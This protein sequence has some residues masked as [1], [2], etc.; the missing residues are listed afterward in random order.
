MTDKPEIAGM[1]EARS[2]PEPVKARVQLSN[3][4]VSLLSEQLYQSPMKAVEELVVN[5]YDAGAHNCRLF[6]PDPAAQASGK[7]PFIIVFDDGEGMN[8]EGLEAL[9]RVGHSDKQT[10]GVVG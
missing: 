8:A 1:I 7:S 2:N 6:V 3:E 4:L 10:L 5:S 9:W